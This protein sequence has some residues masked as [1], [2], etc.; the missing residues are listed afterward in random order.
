MKTLISLAIATTFALGLASCRSSHEG[1][2]THAKSE[3]KDEH[4][5]HKHGKEVYTCPMHPQI[6]ADKPGVCPICNMHLVKVEQ[7]DDSSDKAK[8]HDDHSKHDMPSDHGTVKL[9][10]KKKQ[11]IGVQ[12]SL[13]K[14]AELFKEISAA[15]RIAF[16]PELYTVL[17]EYQEALKQLQQVKD[18]PLPDIRR[19]TLKMIESAK[20]RLQILGL[21]G[22][23]IKSLSSDRKLAE[24]LLLPG[25]KEAAWVYADIYE[26][27]LHNVK[28][29]Q[30]VEIQGA[31]LEGKTISGEVF[32]VDQVLNRK[33][34][35]AKARIRMKAI[36]IT[37]RPE[38]FVNVT[39][40]APQ[41][42][43]LTVPSSAIF[44]TGKESF[45]FIDQGRGKLEPRK[46]QVR[47]RAGELA[48]IGDGLKEG[49][50]IVT[51]GQFLIDSESRL[52][53][54]MTSANGH[55]H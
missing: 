36:N 40:F 39:I 5:G 3:K 41:G 53:S 46:V 6:K 42:E 28:A 4:A 20:L 16:D 13:V 19:N 50:N 21:S 1:H 27:D 48:A 49:D 37:L 25:K 29:G 34:R 30:K 8:V 10:L 15:G 31:F 38:S 12:T 9:S 7:E 35:T 2:E 17:G 33:T 54:S 22:E 47:F 52:K 26:M 11:L 18:S 32:S 51:S 45:V 24:N 44:D 55:Q 14:K 43:H 23:Q